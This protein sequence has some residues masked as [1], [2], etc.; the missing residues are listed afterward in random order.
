MFGSIADKIVAKAV[1]VIPPRLLWQLFVSVIGSIVIVTWTGAADPKITSSDAQDAKAIGMAGTPL[2]TIYR[3]LGALGI[4]HDWVWSGYSYFADRPALANILAGLALALSIGAT[5]T[6]THKFQIPSPPAF[7]WW[8]CALVI[9]QFTPA[10]LW[11]LA[12]AV[13]AK[14][15]YDH[16]KEA[17][18]SLDVLLLPGAQII[19]AAAYWIVTLLAVIA[20]G[21]THPPKVRL[22]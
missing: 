19:F 13:V 7:N 6:L 20:G 10:F 22:V 17:P 11:I 2:G 21:G 8:I 16:R 18:R 12:I 4:P 14:S 9:T 15:I 5:A 1:D 3:C